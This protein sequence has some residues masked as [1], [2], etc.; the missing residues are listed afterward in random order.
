MVVLRSA[1]EDFCVHEHI[2]TRRSEFMQ[3]RLERTEADENNKR[4]IDMTD[5]EGDVICAYVNFLYENKVD[6]E[7]CQKVMAFDGGFNDHGS[8]SL[9]QVFLAQLLVF[10]EEIKDNA[11]FNEVVNALATRVDTPCSQGVPRYP[12]AG[13]IQL[14]YEGTCNTSPARAMLVHMYAESARE[15][16]LSEDPDY[17]PKQFT[18]DL[19]RK[20]LRSRP[21]PSRTS[22]FSNSRMD[23]HKDTS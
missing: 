15:N 10:A 3:R 1:T 7:L 17:L 18:F 19:L 22:L 12:G 5:E 9:Q 23:W 11:F 16:W 14:V 2:I 6:T 21:P 4:V 20:V 8:I 13:P